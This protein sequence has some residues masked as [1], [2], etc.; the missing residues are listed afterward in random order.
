MIFLRQRW[1]FIFKFIFI[2]AFAQSIFLFGVN[3]SQAKN[4]ISNVS[5]SKTYKNITGNIV[6]TGYGLGKTLTGGVALKKAELIVSNDQIQSGF[7][8]LDMNSIHH[9]DSAVV[10]FLK[11][12]D[13]FE[14]SKYSEAI[15]KINHVRSLK[16][17][18]NKNMFMIEGELQVRD[19]QQKFNFEA[20]IIKKGESYSTTADVEI[21]DRTMFDLKFNSS[22][23]NSMAQLGQDLI[24]DQIRIQIDLVAKP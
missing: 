24:E 19:V 16:N 9:K 14:T 20:E 18:K 23:F 13:F 7:F 17:K 15:Y 21:K 8:A 22:K 5:A 11:S 2:F 3:D 1:M 6:W 12:E 4:K 10:K